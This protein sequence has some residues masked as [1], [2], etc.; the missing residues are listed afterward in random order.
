MLPKSP[1]RPLPDANRAAPFC[2]SAASAGMP[3]F[4]SLPSAAASSRFHCSYEERRSERM[5]SCG[6]FAMSSASV[7]ASA[8]AW[9]A[10]TSRL[11]RPQSKASRAPTSRPVRI[12]SSARL[13]PMS[14]GSR[15][16]PPSISGTPQRRQKTPNFA[17]S[18]ATRRSHHRASSSPPATAYPSTAAITGLP[19]KWRVGPIGPGASSSKLGPRVRPATDFRSYPAQKVPPRPVRIA[20]DCVSS[21]SKARKASRSSTAVSGSTA[22][23][24]SAKRSIETMVVVPS[25]S[26]TTLAMSAALH[27]PQGRVDQHGLALLVL[28]RVG[29]ADQR[30]HRILRGRLDLGDLDLD[31]DRVVHVGRALDVEA[32]RQESEPAALQG[33]RDHQTFGHRV[34]QRARHGMPAAH[35]C[36]LGDVLLVGEQ[37]LGK[38]AKRDEIQEVGLEQRSAV[39]DEPV[40]DRE[41][42]P[43]PAFAQLLQGWLHSRPALS[44]HARAA[45]RPRAAGRSGCSTGTRPAPRRRD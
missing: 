20:T 39:G 18:D 9:P 17:V 31:V 5:Q 19:S 12:M 42:A 44:A 37:L 26:T 43:V 25:L 33:G 13:W 27:H 10:G 3:S 29:G 45:W 21:L 1:P 32:H 4:A 15:T 40:A 7:F 35:G 11:A 23:R 41:V 8:S 6:N 28:H 22:L 24:A 30:A 2:A 36:M 16:V 14:R 38:A 34:D